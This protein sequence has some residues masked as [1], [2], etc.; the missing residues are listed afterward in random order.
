MSGD[1]ID[2]KQ[3]TVTVQENGI[4][5]R[6]D[7][8]LIARLEDEIKYEDLVDEKPRPCPHDLIYYGKMGK[9][10]DQIGIDEAITQL[11]ELNGKP[12]ALVVA[13][14]ELTELAKELAKSYRGFDN[15]EA[16][17]E[18][19]SDVELILIQVRQMF[20]IAHDETDPIKQEKLKKAIRV[21]KE[22]KNGDAKD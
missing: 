17:V 18:E 7:G 4:I 14:E 16:I 6:P 19:L 13:M 1:C 9:P 22:L 10:S 5:R 12:Y 20:D 11:T 2:T 8:Y 21:S 15:R 3:I